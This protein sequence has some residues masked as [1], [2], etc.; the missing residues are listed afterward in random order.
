MGASHAKSQARMEVPLSI[1]RKTTE[2]KG[3]KTVFQNEKELNKEEKKN[4][5]FPTK[6][7]PIPKRNK[8]TKSNR[9]KNLK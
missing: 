2:Q 9:V 8:E 3:E 4:K 5:S 6:I 1:R 7:N